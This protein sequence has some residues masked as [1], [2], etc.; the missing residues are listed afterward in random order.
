[1]TSSAA[2]HS[3]VSVI[4]GEGGW[5]AFDGGDYSNEFL[6]DCL[7]PGPE[8]CILGPRKAVHWTLRRGCRAGVCSHCSLRVKHDT[9][10]FHRASRKLGIP[11]SCQGLSS[12]YRIVNSSR[13]IVCLLGE[14]KL[15]MLVL[16]LEDVTWLTVHSL[17]K[18]AY[19]AR[20]VL[21]WWTSALFV[22]AKD[23]CCWG[24][25]LS[26]GREVM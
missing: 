19:C 5:S 15:L 1:M 7:L 18:W 22:T 17:R 8:V 25:P 21:G 13:W 14:E 6:A 11:W 24:W 3:W 20:C 10:G 16:W 9:F 12:N 23:S 2:L 4:P 26:G